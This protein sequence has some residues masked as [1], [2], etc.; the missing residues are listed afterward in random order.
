MGRNGETPFLNDAAGQLHEPFART[1]FFFRRC[2][3]TAVRDP[4]PDGL[5][6]PSKER[7]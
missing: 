4:F 3:L 7:G 2:R 5:G 6:R 1:Q